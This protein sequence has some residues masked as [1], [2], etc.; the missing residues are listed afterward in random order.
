MNRARFDNPN[1]K[2]NLAEA[3]IMTAATELDVPVLRPAGE[4]VRYDLV[5][6]LS[7]RLLR[8]QAKWGSVR[9]GVIKV[10]LVS[11]R[12]NSRGRIMRTYSASEIDA[13]AVYAGQL[14]ECFLLP[15]D[16]LDGK[17]SVYLRIS[18]PN[19]G[20][21]AGLNWASEFAFPGAI[22]QLGERSAGSRKVVGS[23]PTS[24]IKPRPGESSTV[25]GAHEFRNRFG[26][27]MELAEAGSDV[28]VTRRG[29][30]VIRM[31]AAHPKLVSSAPPRP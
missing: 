3:K 12:M 6:D 27:F 23:S 2:G 25:V 26:Y 13:V 7:E 16:I 9:D 10:K 19:N 5:L 31:T 4:H 8:V 1:Y 21:E 14:D 28:T 17:S 22:A 24:S 11:S 15:I 29:K 20:Q 30:P 18:D